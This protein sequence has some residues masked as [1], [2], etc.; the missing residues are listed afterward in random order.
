MKKLF[1]LSLS[2]FV[3]SACAT[4]PT[5]R[6]Q[7]MLIS[8]QKA[9]ASSEQVYLTTVEKFS[10][11]QQ[12]LTDTPLTKRIQTITGRL[13]TVAEAQFPNSKQW[14]WSVAVV[15]DPKVLNAWCMAGG[16]M[17][18]Y[19]GIINTLKLSDDEIAQIMGHEI[20]HAVANHSAERMSRAMLIHW[21]LSATAALAKEN[22][23]ALKGAALAA[24]LGLELPNSRTAEW[25]ADRIG[26]ELAVRAGYDANAA[27]SLW[28][29]MNS[30]GSGK[31]PP[32]FLSTHPSAKHR[33]E[34]LEILVPQMVALNPDKTLAEVSAIAIAR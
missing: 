16:R 19:T 17:A 31:S 5:G 32:E 12:L 28:Q 4:T 2:I 33:I 13:V 24:K 22:E 23:L 6:S 11:N 10:S 20:S 21:G 3:L 25:E 14:D 26:M 18:I 8:P 34:I 15:D 27:V 29:K 9:I 1:L 30:K 7:L